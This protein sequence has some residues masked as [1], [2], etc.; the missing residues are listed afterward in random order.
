MAT[1]AARLAVAV[2]LAGSMVTAVSGQTAVAGGTAMCGGRPAT[3]TGT[4]GD[5]VLVGTPQADVIVAGG[6]DDL[7]YGRG[8]DDRI[9]GGDDADVLRGGPGDD[10][11]RGGA[12]RTT[13]GE[14]IHYFGNVVDGGSGDDVLDGGTAST[15]LQGNGNHPNEV[16]F[17]SATGPIT[18]KAGS[19]LVTGLGVG[20]DRLVGGFLEINGTRFGDHLATSADRIVHGGAGADTLT[21]RAPGY[22]GLYG[23]PGA[24]VLT[25]LSPIGGYAY[26]GPGD[27]R[28]LG[29]PAGNTLSGGS[30]TDVVLGRGGADRVSGVSGPDTVRLGSG[31]DELFLDAVRPPPAVAA[32]AGADSLTVLP[33]RRSDIVVDFGRGR[34]AIDGVT[35]RVTGFDSFESFAQRAQLPVKNLVFLGTGRDEDVD[36]GSAVYARLSVRT[37]GGDDA[38]FLDVSRRSHAPHVYLGGGDDFASGSDAND[39]LFGGAG[40]DRLFAGPGHDTC[41]AE[42]P[43]G[44]EVVIA[45]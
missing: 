35:A 26:G 40:F 7:V 4:P 14:V 5:D 1:G 38:V 9:C 20:R 43:R 25:T 21:S 10:R 36:V 24:D 3:V 16:R 22:T 12:G 45:Q 2:A 27:D 13:G 31:A 28:V 23:G 8:G 19:T 17:G 11:I 41:Q 6:G 18:L 15:S 34:V 29:G 32:G 30:G 37:L 44:C 42:R 33:E 39:F